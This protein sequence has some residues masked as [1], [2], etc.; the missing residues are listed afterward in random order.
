MNDADQKLSK[1]G[2]ANLA[3]DPDLLARELAAQLA[4]D[5]LD[6]IELDKTDEDFVNSSKECDL[7]L[8]WLQSGNEERL[9]GLRVFCEHRDPRALPFLVPLLDEPS[10][11]VR[12]SAVYALGRNP[13]P[14]AID[15]LLHL[16]RFD[17]NAYV[18]K[19]TAWSLGNYPD[20]PVLKPLINALKQDV[21]AVRLWAS[22][23]LAEVGLNTAESSLPAANQLLESLEVDGEPIVR[24]NC[25][26]SLGRLY[27]LLEEEM[28]IH[29][30]E[31]LIS[32]LLNDREPSVRYES[33]T[34]LE[35]L[36]SPEV[37]KKLQSLIDDGQLV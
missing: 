17:S 29:I 34:V 23:S 11:V 10:P 4:G 15:L 16:L 37:H 30:E 24:S 6:E 25:I 8:K 26:W 32:V 2:L 19:A 28:K 21:A 1:E 5:P 27:N 3:I 35:Q 7:A 12:M 14:R 18:R 9:Q 22:S 31:T 20:A 33:R 13:C 36:D